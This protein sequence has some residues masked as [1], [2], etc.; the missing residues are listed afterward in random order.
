MTV[1]LFDILGLIAVTG[2]IIL[3]VISHNMDAALAWGVAL[4]YLIAFIA[5][6]QESK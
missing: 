6:K 5:S 2:N 3:S 4:I 1:S